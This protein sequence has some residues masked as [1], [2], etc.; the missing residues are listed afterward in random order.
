MGCLVGRKA[1][2]FEIKVLLPDQTFGE[3]GLEDIRREEKWLVLFFYPMDFTIVCPTEITALSNRYEEFA[4]RHTEIIGISTDSI[5]THYAWTMMDRMKNGVGKLNFALGSDM[6]HQISKAYG[7]LRE[8][9]GIALRGLFIIN[10][11]GEVQ[12]QTVFHH[13][14][15]RDVDEI[16]RVLQ[17]L[18]CGGLC[19]ANW[20]PG[21]AT[22]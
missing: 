9:D 10:P 16:L 14:I 20:R 18:Q 13:N 22:L 12:Y 8:E 5:Y 4:E 7:V 6:T 15:G 17:A 1:P 11:E 21:Q 3:I 19:P 2:D